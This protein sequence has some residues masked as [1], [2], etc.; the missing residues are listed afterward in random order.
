VFQFRGIIQGNLLAWNISGH[1][2]AW[3]DSHPINCNRETFSEK[4][5]LRIIIAT[6][7]FVLLAN[8]DLLGGESEKSPV[9]P[10][11]AVARFGTVK[12]LDRSTL[13]WVNDV[14]WS[15]DGKTLAS[16]HG[17]NNVRVWDVA[18]GKNIH[19]LK[20]HVDKVCSVRWSPDGKLL[21]SG[22][23]DMT[24][25]AIGKVAAIW[26]PAAGKLIR[27]FGNVAASSVSWSPDGKTL[28]TGSSKGFIIL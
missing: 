14:S 8:V 23:G 1:E 15:P 11:G 20:G 17:D 26:D 19:T 10:E 12:K 18:T 6:L 7:M 9:L 27:M 22:S 21:A 5:M 28:A 3:V 4:T 24:P 25:D 2:R 13:Y 16:G